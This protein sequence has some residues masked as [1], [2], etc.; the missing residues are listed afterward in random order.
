MLEIDVLTETEAHRAWIFQIVVRDRQRQTERCRLNVTLGWADYDLWSHGQY[1][2]QRVAEAV[3]RFLLSQ[4][5]P[6]QIKPAFDCAA[7][8]I[9][10]PQL[11]RDIAQM[12][13]R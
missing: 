6:E 5:A 4:Q 1:P 12:F 11:D 3:V 7:A 8:R 2:P 9:R 10:F 13:N